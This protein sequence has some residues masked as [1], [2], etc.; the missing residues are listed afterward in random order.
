MAYHPYIPPAREAIMAEVLGP[1]R[2]ESPTDIAREK[3]ITPDIPDVFWADDL[4]ILFRQDRYTEF[5]PTKDM[6]NAERLN[7][8]SRFAVYAGVLISLYNVSVWPL[9]IAVFVL[10]FTMFVNSGELKSM[11]PL[12]EG[13]KSLPVAR[14]SANAFSRKVTDE[15][16]KF[17]EPTQKECTKPTLNN[18]FGNM[19]HYEILDNPTRGSACQIEAT[20]DDPGVRE[21]VEENF[22]FNLYKDV[23][24]IWSKNNSQRQFYTVPVTEVASRQGEF[25]EWLYG[26]SPSCKNDAYDCHP[27]SDYLRRQRFY[28]QNPYRNPVVTRQSDEQ[29]PEITGNLP[30]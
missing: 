18:P 24:D 27:P 28:L 15:S 13:F 1:E 19:L 7:A 3:L 17:S 12:S 2:T 10:G 22:N 5:F 21:E 9:Y 6:T 23:S 30:M 4:S 29:V 26:N 11:D 8:I 25:A 16:L 14:N 20:L